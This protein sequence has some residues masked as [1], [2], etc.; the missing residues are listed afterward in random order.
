MVAAVDEAVKVIDGWK[1][2]YCDDVFRHMWFQVADGLPHDASLVRLYIRNDDNSIVSIWE[3]PTFSKV[4]PGSYVP[5][6][7]DPVIR[8]DCV[9]RVE[10]ID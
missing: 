6:V 8:T 1:C 5:P 9:R 7:V 4:S 10:T 3:H 2:P